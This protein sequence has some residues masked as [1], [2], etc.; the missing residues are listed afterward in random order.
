[1]SRARRPICRV[2]EE[3]YPA[4]ELYPSDEL[5][6]MSQATSTSAVCKPIDASTE[7]QTDR[8]RRIPSNVVYQETTDSKQLATKSPCTIGRPTPTWPLVEFE[9]A[10]AIAQYSL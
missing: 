1:M 6:P 9:D 7:N 3:P 2:A 4:E 5:K 10:N 8:Y